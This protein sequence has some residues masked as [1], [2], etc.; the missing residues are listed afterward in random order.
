MKLIQ[1]DDPD[2][3]EKLDAF[4]KSYKKIKPLNWVVITIYILI[5]LF[6]K[7]SW[8][9]L[10]PNIDVNTTEGYWFCDDPTGMITNS[11]LPKLPPQ[12][13]ESIELICLLSMLAFTLARDRYRVLET[14]TARNVHICLTISSSIDLI[15]TIICV[16]L[17]WTSEQV[18]NNYLVRFVIFP[19][20]NAISRPVLITIS[21]RAL[22]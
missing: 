11:G 19:Y 1:K 5:P 6:E 3:Q 10:N 15:L 7:P 8:C 21:I 13:T 2:E 17:P 12:L 9:V 16:S 20:I 22:R 18:T 14:T 4:K